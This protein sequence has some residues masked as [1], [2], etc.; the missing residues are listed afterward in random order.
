MT[1]R[2]LAPW[3]GLIAVTIFIAHLPSFLHRLLDGDEAVYGSIA[4]LLNTGGEL[5]GTGGGDNKPPGIFWVYAAAFRA[6]GTYQM[7]A[8]H[9]IALAVV[10]GTCVPLL[11][12]RQCVRAAADR[13][14]GGLLAVDGGQP[15][16]IRVDHVDSNLCLAARQGQP[17]AVRR[18]HGG[19]VDRGHRARDTLAAPG[20]AREVG[21]RLVGRCDGRLGRGGSPL[22]GRPHPLP[23]SPPPP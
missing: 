8:V 1:R 4:A 22:P 7:T 3:A 14:I 5:Y 16:R 19:A 6:A 15:L 11:C 10:P 12:G 9:R 21:H 20:P 23:V 17:R 13:V 18:R 2:Q